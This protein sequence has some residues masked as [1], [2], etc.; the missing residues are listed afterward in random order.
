M[1]LLRSDYITLVGNNWPVPVLL[2]RL[3]FV[4]HLCVFQ[5]TCVCFWWLIP[6]PQTSRP[7]VAHRCQEA[8]LGEGVNARWGQGRILR[9]CILSEILHLC[10]VLETEAQTVSHTFKT[11][12]IT[13]RSLKAKRSWVSLSGLSWQ[14]ESSD[15]CAVIWRKLIYLFGRVLEK[16]LCMGMLSFC[17]LF[18]ENCML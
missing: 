3:C 1:L 6:S 8:M 9:V 5:S 15:L 10:Q 7:C 11:P 14:Q 4:V 13:I 12:S 16:S 17:L 2:V 18:Y